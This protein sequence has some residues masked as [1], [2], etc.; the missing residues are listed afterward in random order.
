MNDQLMLDSL[1]AGD[2]KADHLAGIVRKFCAGRR[3]AKAEVE[4]L[5]GLLPS[6]EVVTARAKTYAQYQQIYGKAARTIKWWVEQGKAAGEEPP[7]DEP[8]KMPAWWKRVMKQRC[9]KTVEAAAKVAAGSRSV[10]T[11][12]PKTAKPPPAKPSRPV[13]ALEV[14][15][16]EER[17][18]Q[19]KEQ[20][21]IARL[22]MLEAQEEE[23]QE[24]AKIQARQQHWREL[25]EETDK[26]EEKLFRARREAGR[27]VDQDEVG[28]MLMPML[29]TVATAIRTLIV[30]L[31]PRLKSAASAAE[32]D[33]IWNKGLDECFTEL[34]EA[35][36]MQRNDLRLSA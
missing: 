22:A 7:L 5:S 31:K 36:F 21:A 27:L 34:S 6:P 14:S 2:Q 24:P 29:T 9:P 11:T 8:M 23:P 13:V 26:A 25:R 1:E 15:S 3:L 20:L 35:G 19:L 4:A 30:R 10:E 18:N 12:V 17:L 33:E 16:Q 28:A 32:E